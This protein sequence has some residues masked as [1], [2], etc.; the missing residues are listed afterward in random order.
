MIM[1]EKKIDMKNFI[2]K[3]IMGINLYQKEQCIICTFLF[4]FMISGICLPTVRK[5]LIKSDSGGTVVTTDLKSNTEK[6]TDNKANESKDVREKTEEKTSETKENPQSSVEVPAPAETNPPKDS[7]AVTDQNA[8]SEGSS[9]NASSQKPAS[10]SSGNSASSGSTEST[11]PPEKVWVPPV[12]ETVHH[13][14]VYE[15]VRV[16]ICNYCGAT[17]GSTGEFQVHKDENGG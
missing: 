12:Y 16:V 2:K 14:A 5:Q 8:S 7:T 15:T 3:I 4:C 1:D 10:G 13:E 9:T 11:A 6:K 17:F